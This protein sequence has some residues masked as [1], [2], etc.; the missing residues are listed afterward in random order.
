MQVIEE[1]LAAVQARGVVGLLG[2]DPGEHA[3]DAG[4]LGAA[5]LPVLEVE[6]VH[7]LGDGVE[8]RVLQGEPAAKRLE[9]AAIA[10]VPA[11]MP[12]LTLA[13]TCL[14]L[15]MALSQMDVPARQSYVMGVVAP[16][17][18]AAASSITNV[19][20]SLAAAVTPLAAGAM[21]AHSSFG[22]PLVCAGVIKSVYDLLLLGQFHAV[23]PLDEPARRASRSQRVFTA[24]LALTESRGRPNGLDRGPGRC[25]PRPGGAVPAGNVALQD[26][27]PTSGDL[28]SGGR[29]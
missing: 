13:L 1:C 19:P 27:V 28:G 22:W 5:V 20:R 26:G 29:I 10:L 2:H 6:V 25:G 8:G 21:L 17:E 4:R 11:L 14:L 12:T 15:R 18:R 24:G 7:D 16:E 9:R 3:R 23:P